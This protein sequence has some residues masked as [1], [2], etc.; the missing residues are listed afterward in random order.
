MLLLLYKKGKKTIPKQKT[1]KLEK[2]IQPIADISS[3]TLTSEDSELNTT[4]GGAFYTA[5][6]MIHVEQKIP[7]NISFLS[8]FPVIIQFEASA[9]ET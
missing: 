5:S 2:F 7:N 3:R 6:M 9:S 4:A 1:K 8:F